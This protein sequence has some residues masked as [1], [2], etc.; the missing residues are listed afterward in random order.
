MKVLSTAS[1]ISQAFKNAGRV[2]EI[3][4]V[5]I[6]H[7]FAQFLHRMQLSRFFPSRVLENPR[8]KDL[9]LPERLRTSFE[10]LG[11]AFI[12]L[13]QLLATRA[14]LIPEYYLD[15]FSKLQDQVTGVPF[16]DIRPLVESEL[17]KPIESIFSEFEEQSLAAASIAQVHGARLKN[18]ER[19]AVKIQRPGI[20]RIISNDL[21]ILRGLAYLMDKYVPEI[22]PFDPIGIV[23]EFSKSVRFELDFL[24]EANNIVRIRKN[25]ENFSK[26]AIPM[27]LTPLC[28]SRVLVL[29][30]FDGIR[31]SDR[32]AILKKGIDPIGIV[33][34]GSDAFFHMVMHDGLFHGDLHAGNLF[35]LSDG[36]IGIIDFGIVGRLSKRVQ[37]SLT[38]MFIALV[39][40]DFEVLASEYLYLSQST[41]DCDIQLL[42]R[43]LM[44]LISPYM[45]MQLGQVNI[46]KI[47]IKSTAV[48]ARHNL[49]VPREL[50]LLFKAML[51]IESLGKRLD[52]GFDLLQEGIKLARQILSV[53][54]SKERIVR[55]LIVVGRDLRTLADVTPRLLVRFLRKWSHQNFAIETRNRDFFELRADLNHMLYC[56]LL[57]LF[58][59]AI[60]STGVTFLGLEKGPKF[61]EVSLWGLIFIA[62]GLAIFLFAIVSSR[63]RSK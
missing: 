34:A 46:G 14:D 28:T 13:G 9:P 59:F 49:I 41:G 37:D 21:S 60:L 1:Q 7:G 38:N 24:V 61:A 6:S 18:G 31:F 51:T 27:V 35:I 25:M 42:Q 40:E 44:D 16:R 11:P 63:R 36:R 2:S 29:E 33:R 5:L 50:M 30:R 52:P 15:E 20:D 12:K 19:V 58:G 53:R 57:S 8:Y 17:K 48:V 56:G 47:L 54:Y 45:G 62:G 43:D 39:D 4:G 23:E 22:K 10:E 32:E 3:L 26:I 55:D